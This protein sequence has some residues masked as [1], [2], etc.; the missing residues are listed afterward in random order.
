MDIW[1]RI[2]VR[3]HGLEEGVGSRRSPGRTGVDATPFV[4][5]IVSSDACVVR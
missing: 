1:F 2:W 3:D 4:T 5:E